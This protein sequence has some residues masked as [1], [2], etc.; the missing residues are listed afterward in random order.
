MEHSVLISKWTALATKYTDD[1]AYVSFLWSELE[2]NYSS[3]KRHYHN[4]EHI[5]EMLR[6]AA[7]FETALVDYDVLCFAI[8]YHDLVYNI[9]RNDNE[10]RSAKRASGRLNNL[11]LATNRIEN[12]AMLIRSTKN[13]EIILKEN[14][15]NAFLLD[16]DLYRLGTDSETYQKH[17]A[18]IRKEY[19]RYPDFIYF[20]KR[21]KIL[22]QFL[23]R[24]FIY[25]TDY[26]REH[27]E[28]NARNNIK[29]ELTKYD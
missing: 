21:K 5:L 1:T 8:W 22:K 23:K 15:D 27:Y 4:L 10:S 12:C 13:H 7:Q 3:K 6:L 24:D 18:N 2:R 11:Q 16:F 29:K 9:L 14:Q 20:P 25:H 28:E 26:F 17:C 19:M